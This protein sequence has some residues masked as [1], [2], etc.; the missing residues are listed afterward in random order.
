MSEFP[1]G[2]NSSRW[3]FPRRNRIVSGLSLGVLIVQAAPRSGTLI[4]AG[5]ALD[6]GREVLVLPGRVDHPLSLGGL[7]LLAEGAQPV[8]SATD[9]MARLGL[10]TSKGLPQPGQ[11]LGNGVAAA[12][13]GCLAGDPGTLGDVC[14]R[15]GL[16]PETAMDQLVRLEMR[17]LV[18]RGPGGLYRPA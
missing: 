9:L 12:V 16:P 11:A 10:V 18:I 15:I 17:G 2:T 5:W 3:T 6:Q 14:R 1:P 8:I 7:A 4:T 13:V